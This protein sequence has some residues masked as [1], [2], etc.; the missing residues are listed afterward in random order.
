M[1]D[2]IHVRGH[3]GGGE[4]CQKGAQLGKVGGGVGDAGEPGGCAHC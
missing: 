1:M 4:C 2:G 3:E